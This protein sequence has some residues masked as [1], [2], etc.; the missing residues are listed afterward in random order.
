MTLGIRHVS[1]SIGTEVEG[2]DLSQPLKEDQVEELRL[3]FLERMVL[4]FRGQSLNREQ[5]KRFANYFGELH[6]HPSRRN[7]MSQT[8]PEM[9]IIDTPTR[10][11]VDQRRN[12]AFRRELRGNTAACFFA[13]RQQGTS[14]RRRRYAVCEYVRGLRVTV[15]EPETLS[16]QLHGLPRW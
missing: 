12:L 11:E 9:F 8:D 7:G 14:E 5:H 3:L 6:V 1:P 15:G 10:R 13:V 4:V 16:A 2:L